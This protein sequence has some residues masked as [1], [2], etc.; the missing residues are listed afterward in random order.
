MGSAVA[1]TTLYAGSR[2]A[3]RMTKMRWRAGDGCS[4]SRCEKTAPTGSK[5]TCAETPPSTWGG[6]QIANIRKF[7][8]GV[9]CI[10]VVFFADALVRD[11]PARSVIAGQYAGRWS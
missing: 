8:E 9:L 11:A 2:G 10:W 6:R 3:L 4:L 5:N 1:C 7:W